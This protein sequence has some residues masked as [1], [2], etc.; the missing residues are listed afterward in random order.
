MTR[1]VILGIFIFLVFTTRQN[2]A[3]Q[4]LNLP[5]YLAGFE[6]WEPLTKRPYPVPWELAIRCTMPTPDDWE[7]ARKEHGPHTQ[8]YIQV[9]ANPIALSAIKNGTRINFSSGAILAK[10]KLS[11]PNDRVPNA[12]GFMVKGDPNRFPLSVGWEFLYYPSDNKDQNLG[13]ESCATCHKT[14][15]ATDYFFG[16]YLDQQ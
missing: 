7:S 12:V 11:G 2:V 9:Y 3:E 8:M 15:A 14:S 1:L 4:R 10:A 13:H 5:I 6:S 16:S